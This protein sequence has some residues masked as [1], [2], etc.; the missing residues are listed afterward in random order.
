MET[1]GERM[2]ATSF[3]I[4]CKVM[5]RALLLEGQRNQGGSNQVTYVLAEK[6]WP[7]CWVKE[8]QHILTR[9]SL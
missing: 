3:Q 9:V 8:K 1:K 2:R 6:T 5:I 4:C 7:G